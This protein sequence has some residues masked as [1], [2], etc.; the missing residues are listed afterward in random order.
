LILG[1][2]A[3]ESICLYRTFKNFENKVDQLILSCNQRTLTTTQFDE[4]Y[5]YWHKIR[6]KSEF[7]LPHSDVY[8]IT[9]RVS[10]VKAYVIEQDYELC[11][12]HFYVI[13]ELASYVG[14]IALPSLGHIF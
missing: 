11:V 6:T 2:G 8:E 4:F 3:F 10:E 14:R 5:D 9:L 12:A 1:I 7:F 13:K